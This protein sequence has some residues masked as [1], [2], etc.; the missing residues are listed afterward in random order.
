MDRDQD[1]PFTLHDFDHFI[2]IGPSPTLTGMATRTLKA[3]YEAGDDSVSRTRAILCHAKRTKDIYYQFKDEVVAEDT[4][5]EPVAD[6]VP[7]PV[8]A[9]QAPTAPAPAPA[10]SIEDIAIKSLEILTVIIARG[11]K[12]PANEAPLSKSIKE[13]VGSKSTL[14]NEILGDLVQEFSS[15]P[16]KGEE[17][18]LEE[19]GNRNC[20]VSRW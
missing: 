4:A 6:S 10:A 20:L 2:E 1:L 16:E 17:L 13:L 14:Q 7:V 12:K 18:P 9:V 8:V 5:P 19:L 11:L 3:K 15:G